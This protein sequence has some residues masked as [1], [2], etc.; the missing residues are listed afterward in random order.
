[1]THDQ[2]RSLAF[3]TC[4]LF[5]HDV[6]VSDF[7]SLP[8]LRTAPAGTRR[9]SKLSKNVQVVSV[10]TSFLLIEKKGTTKAK[11]KTVIVRKLEVVEVT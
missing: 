3:S 11:F 5:V 1:M 2:C 9:E 7:D 10:A 8:D 6:K 4:V